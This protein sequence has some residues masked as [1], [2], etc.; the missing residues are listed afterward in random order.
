M[1]REEGEYMGEKILEWMWGVDLTATDYALCF[2]GG[3]LVGH[4]LYWGFL[5]GKEITV[6]GRTIGL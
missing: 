6:F 3:C 5:Q 2:L 4:V 1:V